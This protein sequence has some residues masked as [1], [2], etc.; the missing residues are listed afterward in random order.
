MSD[1]GEALGTE[2][3]FGKLGENISQ[4][5]PGL[6]QLGRGSVSVQPLGGG[7]GGSEVGAKV[8]AG[9]RPVTSLWK[10]LP[11][12]F[13]GVCSLFIR[14]GEEGLPP[15]GGLQGPSLAL[16]LG[17]LDFLLSQALSLLRFFFILFFLVLLIVP[18]TISK[19]IEIPFQC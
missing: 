16:F 2:G 19:G 7:S 14:N 13:P 15:L 9:A 8:L 4:G 17:V 12:G 6:D 5:M 11:F 18:K 10:G 3:G 1:L